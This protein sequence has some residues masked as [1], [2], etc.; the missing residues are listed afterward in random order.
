M[1]LLREVNMGATNPSIP[2]MVYTKEIWNVLS[3]QTDKEI[4]LL[5][6]SNYKRKK[7]VCL[8]LLCAVIFKTFSSIHLQQLFKDPT[9]TT[10]LGDFPI[11]EKV[12]KQC[13]SLPMSPYLS[14]DVQTK[15]IDVI[16]SV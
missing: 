13:L 4:V 3:P 15:G 16:S 2:N 9:L 7:H 1:V 5:E 11:A 10:K 14:D 8:F 12:A 6:T